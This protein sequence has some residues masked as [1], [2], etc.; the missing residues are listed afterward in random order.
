MDAARAPRRI[1]RTA[2]RRKFAEGKGC[3][4]S[5]RNRLGT[6]LQQSDGNAQATKDGGTHKITGTATDMHKANKSFEIDVTC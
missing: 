3:H 2:V 5:T 4:A 1:R 6:F